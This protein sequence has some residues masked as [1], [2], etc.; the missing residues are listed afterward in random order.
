MKK[1][2]MLALSVFTALA[3]TV[4][5]QKSVASNAIVDVLTVA[6][7]VAL[8]AIDIDQMN[9]CSDGQLQYCDYYDYNRCEYQTVHRSDVITSCRS[10]GRYS[11]YD[12]VQSRNDSTIYIKSCH[13]GFQNRY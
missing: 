7:V 10:Y 8:V 13:G 9:K 2:M 6:A 4:V 3:L 11:T 1:L 5:P 12:C